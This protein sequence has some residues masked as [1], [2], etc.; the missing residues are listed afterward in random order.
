METSPEKKGPIINCHTHV[1]TADHVPPYIGKTFLPFILPFLLTIPLIVRP[2]RWWYRFGPPKWKQNYF[3]RKMKQVY[4]LIQISI[5]RY[6]I[7]SAIAYV[8]GSLLTIHVFFVAY[9]W[10]SILFA[11]DTPNIEIF[12]KW[13]INQRLLYPMKSFWLNALFLLVLIL[14][15]PAGRKLIF[16]IFKQIWKFLAFLPGETTREYFRRYMNIGRFSFYTEQSR[17]FGRL[18]GQYPAGTQF[19]L[20]PMDME[21]MAAGKPPGD[22][23]TQMQDLAE[24]KDNHKKTALPFV[25]VDPRRITADPDFFRYHSDAKTG[26][27]ILEP[28]FIKTYIEDH[29]F[30]G[31]KIYPALGYYPFD[32]RLL[33]LGNTQPRM[34][35]RS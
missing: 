19:I 7:L 11:P 29:G 24:I 33:P 10:F 34:I 22:F 1:F 13:L 6:F 17:I 16:F 30:S 25:F 35:F 26:K 27:I 9:D 4:Y 5:D 18:S 14:F 21:F 15:F 20:L 3:Y 28:C 23:Y 8:I 32:A 2:A 12:R 31:F